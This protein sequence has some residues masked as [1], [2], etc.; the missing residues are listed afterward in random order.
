M[1][2]ATANSRFDP[3]SSALSKSVCKLFHQKDKP[4]DPLRMVS[5]ECLRHVSYCRIA[6]TCEEL[7]SALVSIPVTESTDAVLPFTVNGCDSVNWL[8]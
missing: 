4:R 5:G 6:V 7:P 8:P 2:L 1:K 3:C